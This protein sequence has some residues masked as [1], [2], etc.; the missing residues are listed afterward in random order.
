[1]DMW[2]MEFFSDLRR[3][4]RRNIE[5]SVAVVSRGFKIRLGSEIEKSS[6]IVNGP[7][8]LTCERVTCDDGDTIIAYTVRR[9]AHKFRRVLFF[10]YCARCTSPTTI[11]RTTPGL[12]SWVR[13]YHTRSYERRA[14][15]EEFRFETSA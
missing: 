6:I 5:M 2:A 13:Q 11:N 12:D 9:S 1:V 7:C 3:C 14:V 10:M 4:L 8:P 15:P